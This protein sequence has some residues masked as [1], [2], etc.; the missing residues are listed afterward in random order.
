MSTPDILQRL[1]AVI[2]ERARERPA[3]SYVVKLLDGGV[4]AIGAKVREEADEVV[5]A[6]ARDDAAHVAHEVADLVFH[7]WVM[8]VRAGVAPSDV[9]A[10]LEERFG[11]GGLEEKRRRG[12][13][14]AGD[15]G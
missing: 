12:Q 7:T 3:D 8:M 2:E 4:D 5:D 13:G 15:A 1:Y 6:A 9:Y 14:E 10:V 11:T